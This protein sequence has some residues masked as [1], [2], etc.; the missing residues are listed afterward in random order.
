MLNRKYKLFKQLPKTKLIGTGILSVDQAGF[1]HFFSNDTYAGKNLACMDRV[2]LEFVAANGMLLSGMEEVGFNKD[3]TK[4]YIYQEWWLTYI[5]SC[6]TVNEK[7]IK[8]GN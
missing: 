4:K 8:L 5:E 1:A 7:N 2:R 3:G 6:E